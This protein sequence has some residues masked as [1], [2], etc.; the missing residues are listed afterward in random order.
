MRVIIMAG[1]K[2]K[3]L[4]PYTEII[5][6]PLFPVGNGK[7]VLEIIISQ[8]RQAGA[9]RVTLAVNHLADLFVAYFGD[10]KK[11]GVRIDYILEK[12]PLHTIGPLTLIKDLPE[13]FLVINGDTLTNLDYKN[14][15]EE[16]VKRGN[17]ISVAAKKRE[18]KTDFGVLEF[19]NNNHLTVFN[20]KPSHV[21]RVSM[22][23]NCFNRE[24]IKQLPIGGRYGFDDL[25]KRSISNHDKVWVY[26]FEGLWL[27]MGRPEDFHNVANESYEE[28][29]KKL[30]LP[31]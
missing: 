27:D 4:L 18:V 22:G 2:G 28:L 5:P 20:E 17:K 11:Y 31:E 19:D 6:K 21:S 29:K 16:H 9:E 26:E 30:C 23:V 14:F 1:G 12:E 3:R 8:L 10:G 25:M 13:N 24:A 15:F 7:A